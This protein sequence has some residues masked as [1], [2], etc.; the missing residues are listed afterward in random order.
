MERSLYAIIW[1]I[2]SGEIT[3]SPDNSPESLG[4]SAKSI[5]QFAH[6]VRISHQHDFR[7]LPKVIVARDG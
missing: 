3:F 1:Y 7:F 5:Y 2:Y 4:T 6:E